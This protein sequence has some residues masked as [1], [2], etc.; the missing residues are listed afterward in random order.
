[1]RLDF[2]RVLGVGLLVVGSLNFV[3]V[4]QPQPA[5]HVAAPIIPTDVVLVATQDMPAGT[6][7]SNDRLD[8]LFYQPTPVTEIQ[9]GALRRL[10]QGQDMKLLASVKT[11]E[12]ITLFAPAASE[13]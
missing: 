8:G 5:S 4:S 11:G 2:D 3:A 6:V 9:E 13:R 12:Q 1:M 10:Y 7:L